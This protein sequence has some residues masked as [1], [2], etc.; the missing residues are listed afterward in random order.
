MSINMSQRIRALAAQQPRCCSSGPIWCTTRCR[1]VTCEDGNPRRKSEIWRVQLLPSWNSSTKMRIST[2][3]VFITL[4]IFCLSECFM[5]SHRSG[6]DYCHIVLLALFQNMSV[7]LWQILS[8]F[9]KPCHTLTMWLSSHCK[10]VQSRSACIVHHTGQYHTVPE[11]FRHRFRS[12]RSAPCHFQ[13]LLPRLKDLT[14]ALSSR[15]G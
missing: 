5:L 4:D 9:D 2:N 11:K 8:Y 1:P 3:Y 15:L 12:K 14:Q 10:L 13:P 6:S 7:I